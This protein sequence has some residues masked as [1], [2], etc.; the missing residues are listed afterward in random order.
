MSKD[1]RKQA[2]VLMIDLETSPTLSW[3]YGQYQT[4]A[5][6]VEKPPILL[7]FSWKWLGDKGEPK[8]LTILDRPLADRF[9]HTLLVKELWKL[10]DEAEVVVAHNINFDM[11]MANAFFLRC[12]LNPPSWYKPFC[13]LKTARKYFKLDNNKLDYLGKLLG[14][15][16]KTETTHADVWYDML[17]GNKKE[18]KVANRLMK[19]YNCLTPDHKVLGTDLRWKEIGSL[20]I[21][22]TI[23][24]FDENKNVNGGLGRRWRK[25]TVLSN[26]RVVDDVYAVH[27]SNG[28]VIKCTKNHRWLTSN[29]SV[30]MARKGKIGGGHKWLETGQLVFKDRHLDGSYTTGKNQFDT[31]ATVMQKM[32]P[33]WTEDLSKDAGWLAGMFDGEGSLHN[34]GRQKAGG[35]TVNICQKLGPELD[36]IGNIMQ[37]YCPYLLSVHHKGTHNWQKLPIGYYTLEGKFWEKLAFLGKVRPERLISKIDW[38]HLPRMEGRNEKV[39]VENITY[40]G[41]QEVVI[42][43]TDTHTYIADGYPMH[44]CQDVNLLEKIYNRLLPFADNHPNMALAAGIDYICPRCGHESDFVLS[45]YR[46]TGTQVNA[47]QV[48]CKHCNGYVTRRLTAEE[49]QQLEDTGSYK[50]IFRN[51]TA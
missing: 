15:G 17:F 46:K 31:S 1:Y 41:K 33:L 48:R 45:K 40:I 36:K 21:G 7:S 6:L 34:R 44:N 50:A 5:I 20:N 51:I 8:C 12:G 16:Q 26:R 10:M 39:W 29:L 43:E 24:G 25:A 9:D 47:I 3:N 38:E 35:F 22:D 23:L 19:E 49:R 32:I 27:L 14:V 37:R 28:D 11:K 30:S 2:K 42:L 13:T 18:Q 4:S